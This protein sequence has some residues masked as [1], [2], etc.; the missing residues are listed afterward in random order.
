MYKFQEETV[1]KVKQELKDEL[2]DYHKG[3]KEN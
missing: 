2:V 1:K 3:Q